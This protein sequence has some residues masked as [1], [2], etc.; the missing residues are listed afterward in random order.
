MKAVAISSRKLWQ[1][2]KEVGVGYWWRHPFRRDPIV[3]TPQKI[4][5]LIEQKL[6]REEG[7]THFPGW[8]D[9]FPLLGIVGIARLTG[10]S[11]TWLK[12]QPDFPRGERHTLSEW[13]KI[14]PPILER[15]KKGYQ[16]VSKLHRIKSEVILSAQQIFQ[17]I[18]ALEGRDGDAA[19]GDASA[20]TSSLSSS[21]GVQVR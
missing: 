8:K 9:G 18:A 1:V 10:I 13:L 16:A 17:T 3:V 4:E 2:L 11:L 21:S 7:I 6:L 12:Q 5:A 19:S 14:L 20:S 15:H